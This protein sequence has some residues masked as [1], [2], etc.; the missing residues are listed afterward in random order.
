MKAY[1]EDGKLVVGNCKKIG[2]IIKFLFYK[3]AQLLYNTWV[4]VKE[5]RENTQKNR[6]YVKPSQ[7]RSVD[8]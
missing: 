3:V 6:K 1:A 4:N 5:R 2:R 7:I 8:I